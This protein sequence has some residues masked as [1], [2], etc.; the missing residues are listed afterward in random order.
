MAIINFKSKDLEAAFL[1]QREDSYRLIN[2]QFMIQT[3]AYD[4]LNDLDAAQTID[5]ILELPAVNHDQYDKTCFHVVITI[6]GA[7]PC[8]AITFDCVYGLQLI[9]AGVRARFEIVPDRL[10]KLEVQL[11]INEP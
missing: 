1:E 4:I 7:E 11:H 9:E 8:A 2:A 5:A 10:Y 3:Q 6:N